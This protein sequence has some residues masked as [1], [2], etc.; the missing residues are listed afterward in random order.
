MCASVTPARGKGDKAKRS[1]RFASLQLSSR[2]I[3][4]FSLKEIK[5]SDKVEHSVTS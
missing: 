1:L 5:K 3:E 2:V 4:R